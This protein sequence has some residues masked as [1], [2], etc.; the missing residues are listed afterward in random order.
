[1]FPLTDQIFRDICWR[2]GPVALYTNSAGFTWNKRNQLFETL[3]GYYAYQ[4]IGQCLAG[5]M[6]IVCTTLSIWIKAGELHEIP[7]DD[8]NVPFDNSILLV[9]L[10]N[11]LFTT[12]LVF[13]LVATSVEVE[14]K[15]DF[16]ST[17]NQTF[18]LNRKFGNVFRENSRATS[19]KLY[20]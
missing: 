18:A 9:I 19:S 4:F 20:N 5:C 6:V 11:I 12:M 1:M 10:S 14:Y 16:P 3:N 7:E 17:F 15:P 8:I 2:F 13:I